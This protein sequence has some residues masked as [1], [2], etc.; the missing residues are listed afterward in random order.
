MVLVSGPVTRNMAEPLRSWLGGAGAD[1]I[2]GVGARRRISFSITG[3]LEAE[4]NPLGCRHG[5]ALALVAVGGG[6][7]LRR[8]R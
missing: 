6:D 7:H 8:L 3:R 2:V 1:F 4:T 5:P